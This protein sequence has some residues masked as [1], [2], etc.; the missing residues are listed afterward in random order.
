[1]KRTAIIVS[2]GVVAGLLLIL[3]AFSLAGTLDTAASGT[4]GES[5][6]V[7]FES[8][9]IQFYES[10]DAGLQ[11]AEEQKKPVFVYARSESC[12]WCRKFETDTLTNQTVVALLRNRFV[13]VSLDA[14]TQVNSMRFFKVYGTPTMIFMSFNGSEISRRRGYLQAAEFINE[15]NDVLVRT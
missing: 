8:L 13:S 11:K 12:Y 15:L 2:A 7:D 14:D 1:M 4:A 6:F 3:G 5:P 9:D 10:Y